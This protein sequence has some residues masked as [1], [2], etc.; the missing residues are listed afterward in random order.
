MDT[1]S[2]IL[3][4]ILF[5]AVSVIGFV[6]YRISQSIM[7]SHDRLTTAIE[8]GNLIPVD[9]VDRIATYQNIKILNHITT[10]TKEQ[11]ERIQE[12]IDKQTTE[13]RNHTRPAKKGGF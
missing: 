10:T 4:S 5:A 13:L 8:T 11:D 9:T 6:L 7:K 12:M 1:V 2:I 3:I